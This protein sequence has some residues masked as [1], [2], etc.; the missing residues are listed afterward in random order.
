MSL[1]LIA[2][3]LELNFLHSR[4]TSSFYEAVNV[5]YF[6]M[7]SLDYRPK[8]KNSISGHTLKVKRLQLIANL[9]AAQEFLYAS[10]PAACTQVAAVTPAQ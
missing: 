1:E 9:T 6:V 4:L 2:T 7:N 8:S 10:K 5:T 3:P